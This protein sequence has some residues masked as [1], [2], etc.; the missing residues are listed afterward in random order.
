MAQPQPCRCGADDCKWC[1]PEW[2]EPEDPFDADYEADE[3]PEY[4]ADE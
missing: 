1:H 2:Q 3:V 4:G